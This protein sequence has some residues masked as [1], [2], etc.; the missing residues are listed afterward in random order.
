VKDFSIQC[1]H[2]DALPFLLRMKKS[3]DSKALSHYI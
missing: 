1:Q 2:H 3:C